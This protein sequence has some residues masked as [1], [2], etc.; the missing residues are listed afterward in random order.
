MS[1]VEKAISGLIE[2]EELLQQTQQQQQQHQQH[3][4]TPLNNKANS[5]NTKNDSGNNSKNL[6]VGR[7]NTNNT[8]NRAINI[9]N[10]LSRALKLIFSTPG[11]VVMVIG[12]TIMGALVFPLLEAPQDI[13]KSAIIAKSRE[14]CLKELWIITEKL[15]VL[16]ERNWTM[17]VHEQLRR[18]EGTIVAATR[19]GALGGSGGGGGGGGLATDISSAATTSVSRLGGNYPMENNDFTATKWSFSEA[20]LYSVTVIT[21]IG[22]GSLTPR[23]TGGKIATIFY[24]LIGVP[25]MLMCLSSLGG[26]L[27]EALQCTYARLCCRGPQYVHDNPG[28]RRNR[29][30]GGGGGG[31]GD[32]GDDSD[33]DVDVDDHNAND[34]CGQKSQHKQDHCLSEKDTSY[35]GLREHHQCEFESSHKHGCKNCKYDAIIGV[36]SDTN[37]NNVYDSYKC[38]T[39][40][41]PEDG[42]KVSSAA[43]AASA[44][45]TASP[46]LTTKSGYKEAGKLNQQQQQQQLQ[47]YGSCMQLKMSPAMGGT[48]TGQQQQAQH[49]QLSQQHPAYYQQRP[50]VMLMASTTGH[51][52]SSPGSGNC[53][54]LMPNTSAAGVGGTTPRYFAPP[55]A[56]Y[57]IVSSTSN[58][59]S[60][61]HQQ[62]IRH[63][64]I[65]PPGPPGNPAT[66]SGAQHFMAVPTNMLRFQT[67][68]VHCGG[69]AGVGTNSGGVGS[70]GGAANL[71]INPLAS[72]S[73]T[74][75]YFPIVTPVGSGAQ[76]PLALSGT[77]A[78][79]TATTTITSTKN[80]V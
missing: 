69:G 72:G 6:S 71:S 31:G 58:N 32:G 41:Q 50:D 62:S 1:D 49:Q 63:Y 11:L 3:H 68:A 33:A 78:A 40:T 14:E 36:S 37:P 24:A 5:Y 43:A 51:K 30:G 73:T 27:A 52:L 12:Y 21:T 38:T 13:S 34:R 76:N 59:S 47:Q 7:K 65:P 16:Y 22:H 29:Q 18:F 42:L 55:M 56:T 17:L 25:L 80:K 35:A 2:D 70:S 57:H 10:C 48:I 75:V 15:N 54:L 8:N 19:N 28:H 61:T 23:T 26:I 45:A 39:N 64:I 77:A 53:R 46:I 4:S 74:T 66:L 20:L 44:S 60:P 79:P 67:S 9:N